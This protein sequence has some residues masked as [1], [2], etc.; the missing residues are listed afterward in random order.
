MSQLLPLVRGMK[1]IE[2]DSNIVS[3]F[4]SFVENSST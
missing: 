4:Q 3:S 1:G 2:D